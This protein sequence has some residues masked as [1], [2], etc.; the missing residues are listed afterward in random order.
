MESRRGERGTPAQAV[1]SR[2]PRSRQATAVL[3][4]SSVSTLL[5]TRRRCTSRN[6]ARGRRGA[7]LAPGAGRGA[8]R[9]SRHAGSVLGG[10]RHARLPKCQL[11]VFVRKRGGAS[12]AH[13]RH[14]R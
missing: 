10:R 14:G 9:W 13:C 4:L 11:H 6:A 1:V 2:R 7:S 3:P 5:L 12:H 8:T